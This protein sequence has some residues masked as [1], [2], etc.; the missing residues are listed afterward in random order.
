MTMGTV[1]AVTPSWEP[2][3]NSENTYY[4]FS[5]R[6]HQVWG[7]HGANGVKAALLEIDSLENWVKK[8]PSSQNAKNV[9]DGLVPMAEGAAPAAQFSVT[10]AVNEVLD[11]CFKAGLYIPQKVRGVG[12]WEDKGRMVFNSGNGLWQI[13]K[14]GELVKVEALEG[15]PNVYEKDAASVELA[16]PLTDSELAEISQAVRGLAWREPLMAD[17]ALGWPVI[18]VLAG[19]MRWRPHLSLTGQFESG[20]SKF[21]E[22]FVAPILA[23]LLISQQGN[24]S[25]AFFRRAIGRS[26]RPGL[27]DEAES[28]NNKSESNFTSISEL[29]RA[30]SG[31]QATGIGKCGPGNTVKTFLCRSAFMFSSIGSGFTKASDLSRWTEVELV[32]RDNEK[33]F[34]AFLAMSEKF[35]DGTW[36]GRF[37][38]TCLKYAPK[39][40]K[41]ADL[42]T[43][44]LK[45]IGKTPREADQLGISMAA[46]LM[47]QSGGPALTEKTAKVF[48]EAVWDGKKSIRG[49]DP[50]DQKC[51]KTLQEMP[52]RDRDNKTWTVQELVEIIAEKRRTDDELRGADEL[53]RAN[54]IRVIFGDDGKA[55]HVAVLDSHRALKHGFPKEF[56][57]W[58]KRLR[59]FPNIE[60]ANTRV[61]KSA[62][63]MA[64]KLPI[65]LFISPDGEDV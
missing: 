8:Y 22:K 60:R 14:D 42:L 62:A 7:L 47:Y 2:L 21:I 19:I 46:A 20:K 54:G 40:L 37:I 16:A 30:S 50:D 43:A 34:A 57:M 9:A 35:N 4:V 53:L 10:K 41:N 1:I 56:Q 28:E 25:E 61:N 23:G 32:K 29:A 33:E 6:S 18:A 39:F 45:E 24:T 49:Y 12:V 5:F 65:S 48:A 31:G 13:G 38:A 55:T 44:A 27:L 52:L 26:S 15:S 11:A 51:L 58:S 17:H 59:R 36:S 64:T 63:T 3:G